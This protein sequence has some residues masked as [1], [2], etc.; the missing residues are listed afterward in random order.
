LGLT[1]LTADE[2]SSALALPEAKNLTRAD[3]QKAIRE[4][5]RKLL[6][7]RNAGR[8]LRDRALQEKAARVCGAAE[9]I[10]KDFETDPKDLRVA[11]RFLDQ[12]LDATLLVVQ[13]YAD[14]SVRGGNNADVREA[15]AGF[16]DL[17]DTIEKGFGRQYDRLLSNHALD[18]DTEITVLRKM[19]ELEGP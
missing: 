4:G 7:I 11:G 16:G 15:L 2:G 10:L 12:Y 13:R 19:L 14:L 8:M 18:F 17:L 3:A 5:Q 1:L 9:R 6:R